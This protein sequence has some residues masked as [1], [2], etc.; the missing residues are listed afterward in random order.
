MSGS[1]LAT[2]IAA[3]LVALIYQFYDENGDLFHHEGGG[4]MNVKTREAVHTIFN[5]MS[6]APTP[7]APYKYLYPL[8]GKDDYFN[9]RRCKSQKSKPYITFFAEK[10][11]T[12]LSDA[13]I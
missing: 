2:P 6:I 1:S 3:A 11:L 4:G 5:K 13:K 7:E 12:V 9:Y 8:T 10:L